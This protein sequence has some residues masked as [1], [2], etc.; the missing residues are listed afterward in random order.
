M[1][2][3]QENT[4]KGLVAWFATNH[5]VVNVLMVFIILAGLISIKLMVREIFPSI[6][7]KTISISVVYPGA[8]PQDVESGITRKVEEALIGIQ[9]IKRVESTA[10]EGYGV[11]TAKLEDFV[12]GDQVLSDIETEV[13]SLNNFPPENAEQ[14]QIVKTKATGQVMNIVVYGDIEESALNSWAELIEDEILQLPSVS[15][16][17]ISGNR[18]R[19]INIEVSEE[20]LREYNLSIE[21]IAS[22]V[23]NFSVDIPAGTLKAE[24][25]EILVRVKERKYLVPDFKKIIIK[26][27]TDGSL[28]KLE[29]LARIEDGYEDQQ[30][31]TSYN[32]KNA[33][34]IDVTRSASQ[35]TIK[36]DREIKN[37]LK[38]VKLPEGVNV[39]IWKNNT[40]ILK[41]RI[42][43]LTRNAIL[44]LTLVFIA[45][46]IFLDLKLAFWTSIGI[47]ISFTGGLFIAS[48]FG[49]TFNMI[50][51]FA[52]IVVLGIVVDDAI[53][54][55]ESIF[56]EQES[57]KK[58]M[59][60]TLSGVRKVISPVTIGVLTTIAAFTPLLFSTGT[61]GQI[62]KP[63]PI[64]VIGI[65]F[66]SLVEAYLILPAHLSNSSKWSIGLI[67]KIRDFVSRQLENL[68]DKIVLPVAK[69]AFKLRYLT[70]LITLLIV[71]FAISL[72]FTGKMKFVFFPPIESDEISVSLEMPVGTNYLTTKKNVD[73]ILAAYKTLQNKYDP[74]NIDKYGKEV[75]Q[76]LAVTIGGRRV[77]DRGPHGMSATNNSSNL[78]QIDV[79]LIPSARRD[80]GAL[81]LEREWQKLT[82]D[83]AGAKKIAFESSLVR[84]EEDINIQLAHRDEKILEQAG[85]ILKNRIKE[86]DHVYEV[87]DTYELGKQEF[88]YKLNNVGLAAGITPSDVGRLLR[89]AFYGIEVDR[90]Q[91]GRNEVKVLVKYP[92]DEV[93]SL[94][95][96]DQLQ[97]KTRSGQRI[98]LREITDRSLSRRPASI[99]RVDGR[100]VVQVTADV[101]ETVVAP[102]EV[103]NFIFKNILPELNERFPGLS[104]SLEGRSKERRDDLST[105]FKNM[106]I[107]IFLIFVLL[108]G[109]LKSYS[110]PVVIIL[111]IPLGLAGAIYGHLLLGYS[112]SF[113]SLFGMVA[114]TGVV[115][116]DSVVLVDY[117]NSLIAKSN[118]HYTA[119]LEAL[120][121]RFRPILLTTLTTSLGL[122]P[123]LLETSLQARFIIPMAIS[124][125]GGIVF[126]SAL[127][128][129]FVPTLLLV[130][131]DIKKKLNFN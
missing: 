78:A 45:L 62:L 102:D 30:L 55:G 74:P 105:L 76:S 40:D 108:T 22:Q 68:I 28:L 57:G 7:P 100:R 20:K 85:E 59:D 61:L 60:A 6:D 54:T 88:V 67:A 14:P 112:L 47:A 90:I 64:I 1:S 19:Q 48:L 9:G 36:I 130:F 82:G 53:V 98:S 35:D 23:A 58:D 17:S 12:D 24:G 29:D 52:L 73:K 86:I 27:N 124:L 70:I 77:E 50:S 109:Q 106:A 4:H 115:I 111:T 56:A 123:M 118:D 44:G 81:Q 113:I 75:F 33:V 31:Q 128:I 127:L 107:A 39:A 79:Q 119:A 15:L 117:Y 121:R 80:V 110:K 8:A 95:I 129:I 99:K 38:N 63:I 66:A 26:S 32:G 91:K 51:L 122:L 92:A 49:V 34:F 131:E 65:L 104:Q 43:L 21:D 11:V 84:G 103:I 93:N 16:V 5:A 37:Y 41:D 101:D 83:I 46:V 114:L 126:A 125:A 13:N 96:L 2:S 116:N 87:V 94:A 71:F 3:K 89:S 25:S 97:L 72:V 10:A 69:L 42:S 18:Q 120:K